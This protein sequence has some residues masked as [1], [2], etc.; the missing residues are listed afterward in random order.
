[1]WSTYT[2]SHSLSSLFLSLSLPSISI[3]KHSMMFVIFSLLCN[4]LP[5]YGFWWVWVPEGLGRLRE[6][7]LAVLRR[8]RNS[9]KLIFPS[10]SMSASSNSGLIEP[11]SPVCCRENKFLFLWWIKINN[12]ISFEFNLGFKSKKHYWFHNSEYEKKYSH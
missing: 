1:M 8:R 6:P 5:V 3:F 10:L 2:S 12:K 9:D 7:M 11:L 4:G